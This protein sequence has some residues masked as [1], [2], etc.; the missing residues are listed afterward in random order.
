MW[1]KN[2]TA[3]NTTK[4]QILCSVSA[5]CEQCVWP[6]GVSFSYQLTRLHCV[7][8]N[9]SSLVQNPAL[10][11]SPACSNWLRTIIETGLFWQL[12]TECCRFA[13]QGP[14]CNLQQHNKISSP[15]RIGPCFCG[16]N[17]RH[18]PCSPLIIE[19]SSCISLG[20]VSEATGDLRKW[21]FEGSDHIRK[22][23]P[24]HIFFFL[25]WVAIVWVWK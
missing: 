5:C 15:R 3:N 4:H 2:S 1:E 13:P 24:A 16:F 17:H 10:A 19:Q 8:L 25:T 14:R 7:C 11:S 9:Y 21:M 18:N 23:R 6:P 12:F 22:H 20:P